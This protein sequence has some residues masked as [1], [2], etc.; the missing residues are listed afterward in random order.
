MRDFVIDKDRSLMKYMGNMSQLAG[1]KR[2]EF[3]DGKA[4]GV[5][6]VDIRTGTGFEY[7]VLP[8]RG[9]DIAYCSFKGVPIS[10]ISKTGIVSPHY[11]ES[12][13]MG[14]LRNFFGGLL[15]TCGLS[16]V[17]KP[18]DDD[19]EI[20][21]ISYHGLQEEISN[22]CAYNVCIIEDWTE[23]KDYIVSPAGQSNVGKPFDYKRGALGV[24]HYGLHGRISNSCAYNVCVTEDWINDN[25][26]IIS[27]SGKV[28]EA[29][30]H[31]ESLVLTRTV[32][33]CLGSNSLI[34]ADNIENQARYSIPLML[35]YHINIG[36]PILDENSRFILN[37]R[38]IEA[39]DE[40]SKKLID[41]FDSFTSPVL[42]KKE[43]VYFYDLKTDKDGQTT[44]AVVNDRLEI[45]VYVKF[46]KTELP[47]F[48]EW[49]MMGESEY[50]LGLEPGNCLPIGRKESKGNGSLEY[51]EPYERKNVSLEIGVLQNKREISEFEDKIEK[52]V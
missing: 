41:K 7:T 48:T 47:E 5:E 24:Q 26:Y 4:K 9:M 25:D 51:L 32:E 28:K 40:F 1:A 34:I 49:K 43:N 23:D 52:F 29:Q 50:V 11:Y 22:S 31:G 12:S 35:L 18:C 21:G 10:Y 17:G 36:Y 15:T 42:G 37:S 39:N 6:A 38:N 20:V 30:L 27:A 19:H 8:G 46:N 33:S 13:G 16:N 44:V 45:G 2:Y 14:W 3:I